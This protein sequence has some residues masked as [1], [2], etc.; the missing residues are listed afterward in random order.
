[1]KTFINTSQREELIINIELG[2]SLE[3]KLSSNASF[4][5]FSK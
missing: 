5:R 2:F 3:L 1:L 4:G